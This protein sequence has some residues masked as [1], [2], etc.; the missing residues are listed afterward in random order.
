MPI[1]K[2]TH[3]DIISRLMDVFR[4]VGYDGATLSK[5]SKA[6]GLQRASLYHRF[7]GGKRE[8]AQAVLAQAEAWLDAH[9]LTP[10]AGPGTPPARLEQMAQALDAFYMQGSSSCL[11][12]ALSLGE[13]G[14]QFR[15]HIQAAFTRWIDALSAL[16]IEHTGCPTVEA[17]RRSEDAVLS[18]QG[19]LVLAR[20]T[21]K[22]EPFQR[23][24]NNLP[25]LLFGSKR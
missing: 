11:L 3:D 19:A 15:D 16:V 17:Q 22:T 9:V 23:V 14:E 6:T 5:L 7:P 13:G 12:D 21:G 10:L 2:V 1:T 25:T 8:M 20:G 4:T 18:I 24:L